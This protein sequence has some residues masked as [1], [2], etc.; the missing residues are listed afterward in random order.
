MQAR[1]NLIVALSAAALL[2]GC[3]MMGGNPTPTPTA[4]PSPTPD[5]QPMAFAAT[6]DGEQEAPPVTTDGSGTGTFSFDAQT[7]ELTY[8]ITFSG[9]SGPV[10]VAHF[11]AG[12]VGV[13]G[14]VVF[15]ISSDFAG[16][17]MMVSGTWPMTA[18]DVTEL[19]AGNIYVNIHTAQNPAGE[20]RGQLI[21]Q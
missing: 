18:D 3:E 1:F 7:N 5:P 8:D 17:V 2:A 4:S 6:L 11:H 12:A 14:G 15:D 10:T 20:I 9:L 16:G 13:A 19:M 21:A